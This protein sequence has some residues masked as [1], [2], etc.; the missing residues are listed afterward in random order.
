MLS[1]K[2]AI[3]LKKVVA[4]GIPHRMLLLFAILQIQFSLLGT[5]TLVE[6]SRAVPLSVIG[7]LILCNILNITYDV[8]SNCTP[9]LKF[10]TSYGRSHQAEMIKN[11]VLMKFCVLYLH[12]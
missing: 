11:K 12:Y 9:L 6:Y 3:A 2:S 10:I 7:V 1:Y 8:L 5:V 4:K